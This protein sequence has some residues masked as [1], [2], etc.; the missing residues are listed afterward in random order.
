MAT[1]KTQKPKKRRPRGTGAI[2][3]I[4]SRK[5]Y[6]G[7]INV[8]LGNG[9]TKKKTVYGK[10]KTEVADKLKE[11]EH[12]SIKGEYIEK[13]STKF[14]D[15]AEK[16]IDEQL[17]LNEIRQ[18]S[19]D[20]KKATLK[21]LEDIS[22][23]EIQTITEDDIKSF[24]ADNLDYS[25]SC[26]NKMFQL[27]GSVF[28]K[29][30]RKK[31]IAE[32]PMLDMKRP[33]SSKKLIPVRALTI[34]EQTKLLDVLKTQDVHYSEIMMLSMFTGMRIG[35]C[36]ALTVNDINFAEKT[37]CVNKTVSRG[38]YGTTVI[39]DT[40]TD[41]GTRIIYI[42]DDVA[43]FLIEYIGNQKDGL[44]FKS[45]NDKIVTTNQVNYSYANAVRDYKIIDDSVYGRVDLHSLRHTFAT[46][47]IESGMPAKVLQHILGHS[48]ISITLNVYCSVFE[49]YRNE[50]LVVADEYM[51]ANNIAI[52]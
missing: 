36:C 48:D 35:E 18:S 47:C 22:D 8:D 19:Y 33:K 52:A 49:K 12:K 2:Y 42:G 28:K 26:I 10:T 30:I 34:N 51:K 17:A 32:S 37:I 9:K 6:A 25:Q 50:H 44:L 5:R 46:R 38:E 15:F 14:Y 21:M 24:F 20:R 1:T 39:S 41:A 7:Q 27:L 11:V 29:A 31:I 4:A 3:F 43:N 40:K 45:R 23:K 13:D 16:M